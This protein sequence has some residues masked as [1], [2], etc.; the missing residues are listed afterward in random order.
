M[1]GLLPPALAKLRPTFDNLDGW[2]DGHWKQ[3]AVLDRFDV[4]SSG[5]HA[6]EGLR[7][8]GPVLCPINHISRTLPHYHLHRQTLGLRPPK[9]VPAPLRKESET[10]S[11]HYTDLA[12]I[13]SP[14]W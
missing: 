11:H 8:S 10:Q 1:R 7:S 6:P 3:V 13:A 14:S 4:D 5:R 2:L 9:D 12:N